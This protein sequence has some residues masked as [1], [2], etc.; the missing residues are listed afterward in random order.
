MSD[1]FPAS[2]TRECFSSLIGCRV[3]G[4][5]F[6]ALPIGRRD[7][8]AGT[9]TL[10]LDDGRGLTIASNGSYWIEN[11]DEIQRAIDAV[12]ERLDATKAEIAGVLK[13]AGAQ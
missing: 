9:R 5:L 3:V 1:L 2:N 6:D 7:L 4:V 10:V 8:S 13:L 12:R 11:A